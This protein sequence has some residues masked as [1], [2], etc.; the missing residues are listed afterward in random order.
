[1]RPENAFEYKVC[2][3]CS[4]SICIPALNNGLELNAAY[5]ALLQPSVCAFMK[6]GS[7]LSV[8]M[9]LGVCLNYGFHNWDA[10]ITM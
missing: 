10:L 3:V 2:P 4:R 1:M 5:Q 7:Q 9:S 6:R 8:E